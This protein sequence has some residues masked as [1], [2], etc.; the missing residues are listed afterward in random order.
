MALMATDH[1]RPDPA[2][3]VP[4]VSVRGV[5]ALRVQADEATLVIT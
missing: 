5:G 2:A 1:P 3:A 4:T